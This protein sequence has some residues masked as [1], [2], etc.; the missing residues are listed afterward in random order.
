MPR[1]QPTARASGASG[2][3]GP[4]QASSG[5][6]PSQASSSSWTN[7]RRYLP[8]LAPD[9]R[10]N[11]PDQALKD[12]VDVWKTAP[13]E[14]AKRRAKRRVDKLAAEQ[15]VNAVLLMDPR[16]LQPIPAELLPYKERV[17]RMREAAQ[18]RQSHDDTT[19]RRAQ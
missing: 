17:R 19:G 9:E 16:E 5:S 6:G 12:A 7:P 10:D 4:S 15:R 13:D 14:N 18:Q 8:G 1:A 11:V 2:A 3:S